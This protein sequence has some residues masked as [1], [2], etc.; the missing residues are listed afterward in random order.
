MIL[1]L[2]SFFQIN[3]W[4]FCDNKI[5][6]CFLAT[7][8][9]EISENWGNDKKAQLIVKLWFK[10]LRKKTKSFY[11]E[12]FSYFLC[13]KTNILVQYKYIACK[14][15]LTECFWTEMPKLFQNSREWNHYAVILQ[16]KSQI[17]KGGCLTGC[18]VRECQSCNCFLFE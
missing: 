5:F 18:F 16:G 9:I 3:A 12:M 2:Q 17:K 8:Q 4:C 7:F 10:F 11:L 15:Y 1:K 13:R 6:L 14:C